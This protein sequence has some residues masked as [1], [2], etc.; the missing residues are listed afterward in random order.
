MS[1]QILSRSS[2]SSFEWI[3]A[4]RERIQFR[5]PLQRVD[6]AVVRDEAERV[7]EVPRGERVGREALVR[8]AQRRG[9]ALVARGP[10]RT[11][12][13]ARRAACPCRRWC[14]ARTTARRSRAR[15]AGPSARIA[16]PEALADDVELALERVAVE[17]AAAR[18]HEHLA[19]DRHRA[20]APSGRACESSTGTSRQPRSSWPSF[21][22]ARSI[23]RTHAAR[24]AGLRGR[25]TMPTPYA[26]A[27][28]SFTPLLVHLLAEERVGNLD[29]HARRR[30]R[31]A[32][33][34]PVAPRWRRLF[35]DREAL[36]DDVVGLAALDVRDE[37][38]AAGVVLVGGVVEPPAWRKAEIVFIGGPVVRNAPVKGPCGNGS[39]VQKQ[40][41]FWPAAGAETCIGWWPSRAGRNRA[42]QVHCS[43]T[44]HCGM[45]LP[46]AENGLNG[47]LWRA[48]AYDPWQTA[49]SR[50]AST[51]REGFVIAIAL[52]FIERLARWRV[53]LRDPRFVRQRRGRR[54]QPAG[55]RSGARHHPSGRRHRHLLRDS[56]LPL[57]LSGGTGAYIV[58]SSNPSVLSVD[59]AARNTSF[60]HGRGQSGPGGHN[61]DDQRARYR[62]MRPSRRRR[63]P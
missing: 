23:S 36:H 46:G 41:S 61:G 55:H 59:S 34:R 49:A 12:P 13:P 40:S 24:A 38:H 14:G 20:R 6:L 7:R 2:P 15:S 29:Q 53:A 9:E 25:N 63:S 10:C 18:A 37:A 35:E 39:R 5:F 54:R 17:A 47:P 51:F 22:M 11:R 16:W 30:R 28:G 48:I 62:H 44:L 45:E 4:W 42:K 31:A 1:G 56:P 3:V 19:D 43:R 32:D 52:R 57:T 27:L 8:E 58:S 21:A 50:A 60:D 33:R 26:P